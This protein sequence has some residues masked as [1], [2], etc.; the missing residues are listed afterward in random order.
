[1]RPSASG[2]ASSDSDLP[3]GMVRSPRNGPRRRGTTQGADSQDSAPRPRQTE[4]ASLVKESGYGITKRIRSPERL[5]TGGGNQPVGVCN[6]A[7]VP[8]YRST[9]LSHLER[10]PLD[11]GVWRPIRRPLA[12][13]GFAINAY[14]AEAGQP[15]IEPHDETSAGAG[16]HQEL[17][18]VASGA[19]TFHRCRGGRR[20]PSGS[21]CRGGAWGNAGGGRDGGRNDDRR[22]R[23]AS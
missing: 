7:A 9:H 10:I 2:S 8:G 11:H 12:I 4:P 3:S 13:T 19:A 1:M 17:Y 15:V 16:G 18:F 23:R 6:S 14:S 20:G 21:T 22:D 5:R